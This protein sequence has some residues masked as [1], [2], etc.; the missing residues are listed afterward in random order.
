MRRSAGAPIFHG[1][2]APTVREPNRDADG[3]SFGVGKRK[4]SSARVW[5][6]PGTGNMAVNLKP[7]VH[8]FKNWSHRRDMLLP[9]MATGT[10]GNFDVWATVQGGGQS[11][12]AGAIRLGVARALQEYDPV[13]YR[14]LLKD[15]KLLTRDA[16]VVERKH[17]GKKK[18][19]KGFTWVKR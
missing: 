16:R 8:Y 9:F 3:R 13:A 18:A 7:H 1:E 14:R 17:Y 19:R 12:Q 5:I 2:T 15:E 6:A 11:G 10:L 4:E